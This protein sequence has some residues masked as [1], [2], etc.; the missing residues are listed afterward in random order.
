MNIKN[1]QEKWLTMITQKLLVLFNH[2]AV[3]L[4]HSALKNKM[5]KELNTDE[6]NVLDGFIDL[7][8]YAVGG[9]YKLT[10][11]AVEINNYNEFIARIVQWNI[12]R[13]LNEFKLTNELAF[14]LEESTE[15]L[16][17][18]RNGDLRKECIENANAMIKNEIFVNDA[19][20]MMWKGLIDEIVE[21]LSLFKDKFDVK[22]AINIVLNANDTK[23]KKTDKEGKILKDK[24]VFVEPETSF[25]K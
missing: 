13:N 14:I 6:N 16:T 4:F 22:D 23:G 20:V 7:F 17:K 11:K 5:K 3:H 21:M 12:D 8:V 25:K 10:K 24:S 9:Y 19:L 1:I 2:N 18:Y 15:L